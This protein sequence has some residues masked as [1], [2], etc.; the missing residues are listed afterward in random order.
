MVDMDLQIWDIDAIPGTIGESV[1]FTTT[2]TVSVVSLHT[3]DAW[4]SITQTLG[5][6]GTANNNSDP[7]NFSVMN[8]A[9]PVGFTSITFD[10]TV[11]CGSGT[12]KMGIGEAQV[13]PAPGAVLL[14]MI[15]LS[16]A[17]VKLRKRA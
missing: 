9:N 16:I 1:V 15:G 5:N 17:G 12:G 13:V 7:L 11:S 3:T 2:A 4:D 10:W 14:G 6:D 8:F